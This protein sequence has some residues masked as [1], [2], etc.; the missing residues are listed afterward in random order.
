M[1]ELLLH[2]LYVDMGTGTAADFDY[3]AD[4]ASDA[5]RLYQNEALV[6]LFLQWLLVE[7]IRTPRNGSKF[8][9]D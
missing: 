3:S 9:H 8:S 7:K 4:P 2:S 5:V 6:L 1:A